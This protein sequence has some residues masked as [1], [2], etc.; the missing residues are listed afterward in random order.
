MP[1]FLLRC[2]SSA[3]L[4]VTIVSA[5]SFLAPENA[6]AQVQSTVDS[7]RIVV[8][9]LVGR[10]KVVDIDVRLRVVD[11]LGAFAYRLRYDTLVFE[12]VQDTFV[13]G[14]DTLVGIVALDLHPGPFEQFA[15]SVREPGIITFLGAD[16]DLD[17]SELYLPGSWPTVGMKWR[18]RIDAPLGL[19]TIY[20]ENDSILPATWNAITN[21]RGETFIRPVMVDASPSIDCACECRADPALCD[22]SLDVIDVVTVIQVAFGGSPELPDPNPLC[23]VVRT[24]VNCD[25]VTGIVDVIRFVAVAFRGGDPTQVFCNPCE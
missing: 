16:L 25:S 15:G 24:D 12:P 8:S 18:V 22:G 10:G 2:L 3:P 4:V 9:P 14:N 13:S 11:T 19:T 23:P 1:R 7:M 5:L 20:F 6:L 17:T 21:W